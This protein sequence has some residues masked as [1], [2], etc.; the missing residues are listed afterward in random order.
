MTQARLATL[1]LAAL[2][3]AAC[4]PR[5]SAG[6]GGGADPYGVYPP[7]NFQTRHPLTRAERS[8]FT[9]T[10]THADVMAFIDTL[11]STGKTVYVTSMGTT[12][13]GRDIPLVVMSRPLVRTPAEAQRLNRPIVYIQGN[14]HGGEVEGKEALLALLRDLDQDGYQ[15][16]LDSLVIVAAPIYNGDG[17][18]A[19]G[20]QE[21]NRSEQNGPAIVGQRA[22]GMGLDLNRDY[23]KAEAPETQA[24]LDFFRAWDPDVFIDLHTTDGSYHGY[25]LTWAP[26][27]NPAARFSGAYTRDTIL[28]LIRGWL[29]LNRRVE[30]FPYG[31]F[32]SQDSAAKGW[33]TYDHRPRFGT[34]YY[35]LR[36]RMAILAEAY[37]H[38]PFRRRIAT[39]Y[40]FLLSTLSTLASNW[41]DVVEVGD[42]ADRRTTGFVSGPSRG[43][44]IAIR[45]EI[46]R[47]PRTD[48]V[49]V[50]E[51]VRTG[52]TI[53]Y[54]AGMPRGVRPTGELRRVKM[55]VYD[56]FDTVLDQA[57]PYAWI[58]APDQA[59]LLP[60]LRRHGI[61]IEQ[62]SERA[63][64]RAE[65]FVI[66][67]VV[68]SSRPFQG[69]QEVRL[70][71]SWQP[72]DAVALD[73]GTYVIRAAQPLAILALYLLDP[74]SDD[75]L[76]TWN[77]TDAWVRPGGRFPV[78]RALDVIPAPL[79][80]AR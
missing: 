46:T 69:H 12:S 50:A 28:P 75:G 72:S 73:S 7:R 6:L 65:S 40:T 14:I 42:E 77:F 52:D 20:P 66:D 10:S 17:N 71:G 47:S 16:V 74:R 80:P 8:N 13:Q 55:P 41:E 61:V 30:T 56:R 54:E 34:N 22:N 63:V 29:H 32:I 68:R 51:T 25:A 60:L 78:V 26:P 21:T 67:S 79:H 57:L 19:M 24:A 15:N 2:G 37:S 44:R 18:D 5:P 11:K 59:S 31:N 45:S 38:D 36:G 23:I 39:M 49:L 35:G 76:E 58:I 62:L 33:Y 1:L 3:C 27:L 48:D 43:P 9:E 4:G 53:R 64:V 70:E